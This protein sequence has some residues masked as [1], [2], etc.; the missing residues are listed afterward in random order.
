MAE[1]YSIE[2]DN[3]MAG[4]VSP[5]VAKGVML[6]AGGVRVRGTVLGRVGE[7]DGIDIVDVVN[8]T[9]TDGSEKPYGIL[10]DVAVDATTEDQRASVY[11]TGEFNRDALIF[12]GTDTVA[13]HE[14]AMREVGIF[15]KTTV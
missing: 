9:K 8:S 4:G 6:K 2:Y 1:N 15:V 14:P 7:E 12:G 10:A 3:L 5:V 13:T 11:L